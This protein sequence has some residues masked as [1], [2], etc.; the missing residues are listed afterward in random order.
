MDKDEKQKLIRKMTER[1]QELV[2]PGY[3]ERVGKLFNLRIDRYYGV[4][5]PLI[6]SLA[7]EYFAAIQ[8]F[9][10]EE[11]LALCSL[12]LA[13]DFHELKITAYQWVEQSKRYLEE[14]HLPVLEGWLKTYTYDWSDCDDICTNVLGEFF[15]KYPSKASRCREWALSKNLW[16]RRA[17]AVSLIKPLRRGN[18]L[19]LC[20]DIADL[21]LQDSENLVQKG[22]GWMLKEASK[23]RPDEVY[24]FVTARIGTMPRT[25]YRYALEKFPHELRVRA[26]AL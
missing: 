5:V 10:M 25:A 14:K 19:S 2:E 24:A 1:F 12:L 26:L 15:L 23:A 3:R 6:R 11:R 9:P 4:R 8:P 16:V 7:R 17:A 22:Y 13:E 21:L 20:L 18:L